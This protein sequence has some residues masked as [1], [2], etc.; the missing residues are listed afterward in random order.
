MANTTKRKGT[1]SLCKAKYAVDCKF[2]MADQLI[3]HHNATPV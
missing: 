2:S 3:T 1:A